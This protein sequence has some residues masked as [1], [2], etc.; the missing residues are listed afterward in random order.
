MLGAVIGV[1]L[2]L[3]A[4]ALGLAGIATLVQFLNAVLSF[5]S[6]HEAIR[7]IGLAVVAILGAPF[8]VWR[9]AVAQKQADTG[10][11]SHITDQI[12]KAVSGLGAEKT[13]DRIG[14]PVKMYIGKS[15][16]V[17]HLVDDPDVF[18]MKPRSL[19]R[20]RYRDQTLLDNHKGEDEVFDGMHIEVETW[21]DEQT[22]IEWQS[23]PLRVDEGAAIASYGDWAVFSETAPNIEVRLGAIYAL[24]RICQDIP[25]DHIR[26]MEIL[27]AY[28]REN[29]PA[30]NLNPAED[31]FQYP[32]PRTDIQA[33]LDVVG[34]RGAELI[35][36]EHS[37]NYRLDLRDTDLSRA[38]FAGGCFDG[39]L[40]VG[41]RLEAANLRKASFRGARLQGA[42][43]NCADFYHTDLCGALLDHVT[44][45]RDRRGGASI[46]L[47]R[48]LRGLS[49]AGAD[50]A[51]VHYLEI[52]DTRNPTFGT[53]DTVLSHE[54]S[55]KYDAI[56]DDLRRYIGIRAGRSIQD[57]H[58]VVERV[59]ASEFLGWSPY[60]SED[61]T[62]DPLR[63]KL[64]D[65]LGLTGFPFVDE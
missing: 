23:I 55:Q 35:A 64:W 44:I 62:T 19:E 26:I 50:I 24:E 56:S 27:T 52:G 65:T 43:L 53:K 58:D 38:N 25:R 2:G 13:A 36:L 9:A 60:R 10:E 12:N 45:N 32:R 41:C 5:S 54:L 16:K 33:A 48:D 15:R 6:D 47:A 34:R 40:L 29:A 11:Q 20:A 3:M 18:E 31:P 8:V 63:S 59:K 61:L 7:N 30:I 42:L 17:T 14:R 22:E 46:S 21:P 37:Q 49:I 51:S 4:I 39:A 28:I 1:A 57:E